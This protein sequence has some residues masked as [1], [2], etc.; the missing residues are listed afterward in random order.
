MNEKAA[1]LLVEDEQVQ[2]ESLAGY[3]RRQGHTVSVA[4]EASKA[5]HLLQAEP[6]D[7]VLSDFKMPGLNGIQLLEKVKEFNPEIAVVL[8]TAYGT[9]ADAVKAMRLGAWD[10]LTKPIDLDELDIILGRALSLRRLMNENR[11]LKEQFGEKYQFNNIITADPVMEEVLNLSARSARSKASILIQGPSGTGKELMARAIHAASDRTNKPMIT[12]NC[13]AITESLLESEL[14]GHEKGSFTG[15]V[16]RKNGRVEEANGGTLFIDE[17]GDIP[18][19]MQVKLLRFLQFGEFQRV[20]SNQV[21]HVD[22]RLISA[23]NRNLLAMIEEGRYREDFYYRLNVINIQVPGLAARKRDI[24]ILANHFIKKSARENHRDIDGLSRAA[25]DALL[26][27][28]F[29]GNV[30]ELEN[31]MERAVILARGNL[32][33]LEEL[34]FR[35]GPSPAAVLSTDGNQTLSAQV[36]YFERELIRQALEQ[37]RNNQSAAARRLGLNE[38]NLRYKL[39]KYNL[40]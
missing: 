15:A 6:V 5:L 29:P 14:F 4:A 20:G 13:A 40:K 34:P 18:L 8:M 17:V 24:P 37:S 33:G 9:I 28:P 2:R 36:E 27:Y 19:S 11:L 7:I 1:L 16:G 23:T 3:L 21:Q 25:Q 31:M 30:R 22:V 38:R 12:V 39:Q 26:R 35:P 32:I 10:Y